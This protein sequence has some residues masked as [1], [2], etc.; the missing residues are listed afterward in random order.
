VSSSGPPSISAVSPASNIIW[1]VADLLGGTTRQRVKL[2]QQIAPDRVA[3]LAGIE[4]R[5]SYLNFA[6]AVATKSN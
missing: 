4:N 2:R 6:A 5:H 3:L 1:R